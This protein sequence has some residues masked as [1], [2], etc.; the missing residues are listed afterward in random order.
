MCKASLKFC[1]ESYMHKL[2]I[3]HG[4][5]T[6]QSHLFGVALFK[7]RMHKEIIHAL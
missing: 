3:Y 4:L 1:A 6:K 2:C 7:I 5:Q